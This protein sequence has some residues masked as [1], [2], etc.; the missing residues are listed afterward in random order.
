M[1]QQPDMSASLSQLV[2]GTIYGGADGTSGITAN[3]AVENA[4]DQLVQL[5]ASCNFEETWELIGCENHMQGRD[6]N[7]DLGSQIQ[8][9][10]KKKPLVITTLSAIGVSHW[11]MLMGDSQM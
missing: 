11:E 4:F 8:L 5:G 10:M 7:P 1:P 3:P 9:S 6:I 2:V